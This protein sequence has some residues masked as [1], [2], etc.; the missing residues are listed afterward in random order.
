MITY[1]SYSLF[2]MFSQQP[3]IKLGQ[4]YLLIPRGPCSSKSIFF[5]CIDCM[6]V[7]FNC[8]YFPYYTCE[9]LECLLGISF[10]AK[11]LRGQYSLMLYFV[12]QQCLSTQFAC[13]F[14]MTTLNF[15]SLFIISPL[16]SFLH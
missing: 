6:T 13:Y 5:F 9:L 3:A 2:I 10:W 11:S 14:F 7:Y 16:I 15:I 4:N 1:I 8:K 12:V